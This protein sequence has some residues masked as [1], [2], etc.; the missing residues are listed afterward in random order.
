MLSEYHKLYGRH[1][2]GIKGWKKLSKS[3]LCYKYIEN[4]GKNN[5]KAECYL[6]ALIYK[7]LPKAISYFRDQPYQFFSEE[8]CYDVVINSILY[9]LEKRVWEKDDSSLYDKENAPE[10]ALNT[11]IKTQFINES[12]TKQYYKRKANTESISLTT[13]EDDFSEG[14][15]TPTV[16]YNIN[17]GCYLKVLISNLFNQGETLKAVV[18]DCILHENVFTKNSDNEF[19]D[20]KL[21]HRIETL[22]K[23]YCKLFSEEYDVNV[24]DVEKSVGTI[25]SS[26]RSVLELSIYKVISEFSRSKDFYL[27]LKNAY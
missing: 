19:C 4:L 6:S 12:I 27:S 10:I 23:D 21:I 2:N 8:D 22:D 13:M 26:K 5:Y 15:L 25:K 7:M 1:A 11:R 24:N 20:Y 14:Y 16:D 17:T 3:E 9:V 18:L